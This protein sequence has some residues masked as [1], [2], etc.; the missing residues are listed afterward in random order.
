MLLTLASTPVQ[1][2]ELPKRV[3]KD[4]A[5]QSALSFA[6]LGGYPQLELRH[7]VEA[8]R[9]SDRDLD[10]LEINRP[11]P[12]LRR[13]QVTVTAYASVPWA[14][15]DTPYQTASGACVSDGIVAANFLEFGTRL[16]MP[17][18]FGEKVFEVQDRMSARYPGRVDIWMYSLRENRQFGIKRKVTIEIV[19]VGDGQNS[20]RDGLTDQECQAQL[21][22]T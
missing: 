20:W 1:A 7:A 21:T 22:S 11:A 10:R 18:L 15:D 13:L 16:R 6:R 14:T 17:E 12:A 2:A 3:S 19:T 9:V 5:T 8:A 4:V